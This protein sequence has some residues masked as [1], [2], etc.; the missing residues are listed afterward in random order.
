[1]GGGPGL[2][3]QLRTKGLAE[4]QPIWLL[5]AL[6]QEVD[7]RFKDAEVTETE[8]GG[9]LEERGSEGLITPS[10]VTLKGALQEL[11]SPASLGRQI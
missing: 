4:R 10:Q 2:E 11:T 6:S 3:S 5:Q 7:K 9:D 8:S 1:M